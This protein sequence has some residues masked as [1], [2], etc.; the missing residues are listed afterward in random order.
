MHGDRIAVRSATSPRARP[1]F[2]GASGLWP[3]WSPDGTRIVFVVGVRQDVTGL[4]VVPAGGGRERR[5]LTSTSGLEWPSWS[6]DGR[7]I[8]YSTNRVGD[9]GQI[10]MW[11]I[12]AGGGRPRLLGRGRSIDQAPD[13]RLAFITGH[14]VWTARGDGTG[15]RRIVDHPDESMVWRLAWS[16]DGSRLA[17]V[18]YPVRTGSRH[19]ARIV[20]RNGSGDRRVRLP[21]RVGQPLYIHWGAG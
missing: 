14:D 5:V 12:P 16:P 19:H 4:A 8:L 20:R 21:R 6:R 10:R 7:H 11:R 15:R 17:Y 13:G 3:A 9:P 18:F 1:R 2:V